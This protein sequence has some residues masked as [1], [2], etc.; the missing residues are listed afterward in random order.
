MHPG[1]Y[2]PVD[3]IKHTPTG[4][5]L[6]RRYGR[7][8]V[9]R[10]RE[11]ESYSGYGCVSPTRAETTSI[12][13]MEWVV[14]ARHFS[15]LRLDSRTNSRRSFSHRHSVRSHLQFCA[16]LCVGSYFQRTRDRRWN[17]FSNIR[18]ISIVNRLNRYQ[19]LC[20]TF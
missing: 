7:S 10:A 8:F 4:W 15:Y 1:G 14:S 17:F 16:F 2:G 3:S 6:I 20:S 9:T 18:N 12:A 11:N 13:T 19:F 5:K